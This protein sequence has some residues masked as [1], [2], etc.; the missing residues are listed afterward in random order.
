MSNLIIIGDSFSFGNGN[1]NNK[2]C[3]S[4]TWMD[5]VSENFEEHKLLRNSWPGRDVQTIIDA[6]IKII[7]KLKEDDILVIG[8][9]TIQRWRMPIEMENWQ[10]DDNGNIQLINR[11]TTQNNN[12]SYGDDYIVNLQLMHNH[13][14]FRYNFIEIVKSLI[15][16]TP[17]HKYIWSWSDWMV[18]DIGP[19]KDDIT[20]QIGWETHH[21]EYIKTNGICGRE[22]D[23]HF[24]TDMHIKFSE[25]V[26]ESINISINKKIK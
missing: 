21:D 10:T 4:I 24:S 16:L 14:A 15:E 18:P 3:N 13:D 20:K 25:L 12:G 7:P 5:L 19:S 11:F 8:F 2:Q 26:I 17:C 6:W 9:P 22:G 23:Y 1:W